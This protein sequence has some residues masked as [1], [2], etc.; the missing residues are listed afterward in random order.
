MERHPT[1]KAP[2]TLP[3]ETPEE[4]GERIIRKLLDMP[5]LEQTLEE[6]LLETDTRIIHHSIAVLQLAMEE[7]K[8]NICSRV[9][10][11]LEKHLKGHSSFTQEQQQSLVEAAN[12][13]TK[14]QIDALKEHTKKVIGDIYKIQKLREADIRTFCQD[15]DHHTLSPRL[16]AA[17]L[18]DAIGQVA[19]AKE[20]E[21]A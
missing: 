12:A 15:R 13:F 11:Q 19:S 16:P 14:K 3:E 6:D 4:A 1:R 9:A 10:A 8:K 7:Q 20:G 18:N 17:R 2:R 21:R 5:S